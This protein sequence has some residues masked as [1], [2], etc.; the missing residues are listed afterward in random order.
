MRAPLRGASPSIERTRR[1]CGLAP[2]DQDTGFYRGVC[3]RRFRG[4]RTRRLQP[5]Y[6]LFGVPKGIRTPVTAVKGR[7]PRPLDDGDSRIMA[8]LSS[9]APEGRNQS[10][11]RQPQTHAA[12]IEAGS[13]WRRRTPSIG[14]PVRPRGTM[15]LI[16]EQDVPLLETVGWEERGAARTFVIHR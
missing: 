1:R 14:H 8:R 16:E 5:Y 7:C 11:R 15:P 12:P 4:L 9:K 6:R 3:C 13:I 10:P 2:R